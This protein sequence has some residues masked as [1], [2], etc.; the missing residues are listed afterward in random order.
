MPENYSE[1]I[2]DLKN[3]DWKIQNVEKLLLRKKIREKL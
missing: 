1:N 3:L 2:L